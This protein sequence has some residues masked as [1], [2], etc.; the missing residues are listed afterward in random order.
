MVRMTG[1]TDEPPMRRMCVARGTLLG[2]PHT[3]A[4]DVL[5]SARTAAVFAVKDSGRLLPAAPPFSLTETFCDLDWDGKVHGWTATVTVVGYARSSLDTAA[6]AGVGA[7]LLQ[8]WESTKAG[9]AAASLTMRATDFHVVQ[10]V[11]G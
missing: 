3:L 9:D 4:S 1:V 8:L 6:L 2:A 11:D 5:A 10:N 7:A